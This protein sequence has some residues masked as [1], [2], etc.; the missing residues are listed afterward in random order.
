[1]HFDAEY[2]N[3]S[4]AMS[5]PTVVGTLIRYI[6]SFPVTIAKLW[7]RRPDIVF[8][9]NQP[10]FLVLAVAAYCKLKDVP[11]I[12]DSHSGPFN[13]PKWRWSLP[14]YRV[15]ARHALL[16]INHTDHHKKV[17]ESW[18]GDSTTMGDIPIRTD[19]IARNPG[20]ERPYIAVVMS[21]SFDEPVTEI[22]D[23]A[24][25][26]PEMHFYLSG[27]YNKLPRA[28]I[29]SRPANVKLTGHLPFPRYLGLLRDSIGIMVLTTRDNTMQSGAYEALS[30]GVPIITSDFQVLR[31][32]F[33][34]AAIYVDNTADAIAEA[35]RNLQE[36]EAEMREAVSRQQ[37][38][39][40]QYFD[41]A[42]LRIR[43]AYSHAG[44]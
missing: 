42:I 20:T 37:L 2:L 11:Y 24:R 23:A 21:F 12:I 14:L 28:R 35:V 31:D 19:E 32:C 29:D 8:T 27:N 5:I 26:V 4:C 6:T 40:K 30:L 16:N 41:N 36:R 17:V 25:K 33:G 22:F 15:L 44:E 7:Q 34:D 1:V 43:E 10:I 38:V 18:G 13:D 9:K 39:R 3:V